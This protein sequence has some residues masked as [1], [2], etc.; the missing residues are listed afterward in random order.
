MLQP[1]AHFVSIITLLTL[2]FS[3]SNSMEASNACPK[4]IIECNSG[5][6][7][8]DS[9]FEFSAQIKG[10]RPIDKPTY[11]WLVS[12]GKIIS[13]QGTSA[14]KVDSTEFKGKTVTAVLEIDEVEI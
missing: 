6:D 8:C 10:I 2:P 9:P 1:I 11:K 3:S 13:G 5:K 4:I 7:C 12:G 14:I